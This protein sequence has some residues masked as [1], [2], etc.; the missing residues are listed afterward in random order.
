MTESYARPISDA[1]R[2][3]RS[4]LPKHAFDL[5]ELVQIGWEKVL[6]YKPDPASPTLVFV[7]AKLA[8]LN[9]YDRWIRREWRRNASG[10]RER[11]GPAP[12]VEEYQEWQRSEPAPPIEA[13]IDIYRALLRM[14]DEERE[15]W[16]ATQ[17]D[18]WTLREAGQN[19]GCQPHTV[20]D[21]ARRA[22]ERLMRVAHA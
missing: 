21:R 15:A 14:R 13:L 17:L 1:A 12:R 3:V 16:T 6:R 7:A 20:L 22:N 9:A 19:L 4:V 11:I 18:Q 5:D 10:N 8:M 2:I